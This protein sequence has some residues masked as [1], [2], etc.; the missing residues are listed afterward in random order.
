MLLVD[1]LNKPIGYWQSQNT[2]PRHMLRF[3]L[4]IGTPFNNGSMLIRRELFKNFEHDTTLKVGSDSD[5]VFRVVPGY[6]SVH[7][8][9]PLYVYRRHSSNVTK[10]A[11]YDQ[12]AAHVRKLLS[13]HRLEELV[14]ELGWGSKKHAENQARATAIIALFL[15]RRNM[16]IDADEWI[17]KANNIECGASG[18]L[19]VRA[20]SL[21]INKSYELAKQILLTCKDRDCVIDNYLGEIA[22]YLGDNRSAFHLFLSAIEKNPNYEEPVDNLRGLGGTENLQMADTT[23]LKYKNAS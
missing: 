19:F 17:K 18:K 1:E 5:M 9:E 20:I 11:N 23:W 7:I 16:V 3:F 14:P 10:K 12:I 22:A 2:T 15:A 8:A 13:R 4:K 6:S 21:M